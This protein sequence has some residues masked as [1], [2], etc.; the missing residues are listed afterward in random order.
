MKHNNLPSFF[1]DLLRS[2]RAFLCFC[3]ET[4]IPV[5]CGAN[6]SPKVV[7]LEEGSEHVSP[8]L[9]LLSRKHLVHEREQTPHHSR[10]SSD[11]H[12]VVCLITWILRKF[13]DSSN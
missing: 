11:Q 3:Y 8:T 5:R 10:F 9:A 1:P 2:I 6:A 13:A 7:A 4:N 12:C